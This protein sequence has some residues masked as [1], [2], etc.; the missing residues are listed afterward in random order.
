MTGTA[1]PSRRYKYRWSVTSQLDVAA[2]LVIGLCIWLGVTTIQYSGGA[3]VFCLLSAILF[4]CIFLLAHITY[5]AIALEDDGVGT[6]AF[7]FRCKYVKWRDVG[8]IRKVREWDA[9]TMRYLTKFYVNTKRSSINMHTRHIFGNTPCQCGPIVFDERIVDLRG[10]LNSINTY[11]RTYH[12]EIV[13][14]DRE[15]DFQLALQA[16]KSWWKELNERESKLDML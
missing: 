5:S 9:P 2:P 7:G 11:A 13:S 3:A 12:I 10:L 4:A 6:Y 15:A 8:K 14:V 16:G 1:A